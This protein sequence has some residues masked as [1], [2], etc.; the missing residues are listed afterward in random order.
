MSTRFAIAA[1]VALALPIAAGSIA[2]A[3]HMIPGDAKSAETRET[4]KITTPQ[5]YGVTENERRVSNDPMLVGAF[6]YSQRCSVC[7]A[8]TAS[9]QQN[10]GPHLEGIIGRK[11]GATAWP[12]QTA[13]LNTSGVVWDEAALD[14]LLRDPHKMMPGV[15]M[16]VVVRFKRSRAALIHYLKSL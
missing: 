13:A 3:Q 4:P 7:H 9:G 8:T 15:K 10:Y 12:Q 5:D 6:V 16:D 14:A 2:S 11:A 1:A